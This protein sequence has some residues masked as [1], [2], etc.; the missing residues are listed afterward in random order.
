MDKT[1]KPSNNPPVPEVSRLR[2]WYWNYS[3]KFF[4]IAI[5]FFAV[6]GISLLIPGLHWR[7]ILLKWFGI[8]FLIAGGVM[9]FFKGKEF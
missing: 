7:I 9:I 8:G 5:V 1:N 6:V 3:E 4:N 2:R